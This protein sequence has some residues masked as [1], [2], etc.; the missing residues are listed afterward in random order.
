MPIPTLPRE[1]L[2]NLFWLCALAGLCLALTA[3][4]TTMSSTSGGSQGGKTL[5]LCTA[6]PAME[7]SQTLPT[8]QVQHVFL[9]VLENQSYKQVIGNTQAMPYLNSLARR[10]AYAQGYYA[11][12]H[13][14]I[15]NYFF[16]TA[17]QGITKSDSFTNTVSADNIV[18]H[19]TS[20]GLTWKSYAEDIP[21]RGYHGGD[22]GL[23]VQ[24]H[25]PLSYFSDVRDN[26]AEA[27]NLVPFSTLA[28]DIAA[29]NLPNYGFIIPNKKHDSHDCPAGMPNC[30]LD[31]KLS[32]VDQWLQS[33]LDP[34]LKSPDFSTHG[35]GILVIAFDESLTSDVAKGGGHTVWVAVGPDIRQGY[36]STACYQHESTL[37]FTSEVLGMNSFPGAAATA[38]D[39]REFLVGN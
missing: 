3:G 19:L 21:G 26:P 30:T 11:D 32:S 17:G 4:G 10:Y 7:T 14:S 8:V 2:E 15:P 24:H 13:P 9:V 16:L 35:G 29:H 20:A 27:A 31:Q 28:S 33:N 1:K 39:M 25:N 18:R 22:Q 5:A 23:Y 38:P 12:A 37:R 6:P 36:T 34:L